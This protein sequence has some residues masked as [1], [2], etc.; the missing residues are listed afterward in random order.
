MI[1][2][3]GDAELDEIEQRAGRALN[4]A[5]A[6]RGAL[7]VAILICR[8]GFDAGARRNRLKGKP[9][10]SKHAFDFSQRVG[11]RPEFVPL[12]VARAHT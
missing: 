1:D 6:H 10:V 11:F 2:A 8:D 7:L 3:I 5:P 4:V 12:A 9:D